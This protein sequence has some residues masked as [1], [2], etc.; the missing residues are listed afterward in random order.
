MK[1]FVGGLAVLFVI[2]LAGVFVFVPRSFRAIPVVYAAVGSPEYFTSTEKFVNTSDTGIYIV[3]DM[4]F[5]NSHDNQ[6]T[7]EYDPD[8]LAVFTGWVSPDTSVIH[9]Q[10][11]R[12]APV[13][14]LNGDWYTSQEW[15][16]DNGELT[17][18]VADWF[19]TDYEHGVTQAMQTCQWE[20]PIISVAGKYGIRARALAEV[21]MGT[22]VEYREIVHPKGGYYDYF[23]TIL[24]AEDLTSVRLF[25]KFGR[26]VVKPDPRGETVI[27]IIVQ[28]NEGAIKM[29]MKRNTSDLGLTYEFGIIEDRLDFDWSNPNEVK[30]SITKN[31]EAFNKIG[32]VL[33]NDILSL[34]VPAKLDAGKYLIMVE[35]TYNGVVGTFIID[36]GDPRMTIFDKMNMRVIM[37]LF[38]WTGLIALFG[39]LFIMYGSKVAYSMNKTK[40]KKIDDKI[41]EMD[42]ASIRKREKAEKKKQEAIKKGEIKAERAAERSFSRKMEEVQA[43]REAARAQGMTMEE[44]KKVAAQNA[45]VGADGKKVNTLRGV[46]AMIAEE[47]QITEDK[48]EPPSEHLVKETGKGKGLLGKIETALDDELNGGQE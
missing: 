22:S 7:E 35:H 18:N 27:D 4:T 43:M 23:F 3:R 19:Y 46:R 26:N 1:K 33:E 2:V 10:F 42:A 36:N 32:W 38:V 8:P 14:Y 9:E 5:I 15:A 45:S 17:D 16:I 34:T 11:F 12:F 47:A 41:Y 29:N 31:G 28:G 25:D 6:L 48:I 13:K 39:A 20:L 37:H 21:R 40:Y 24:Y 44:Y 30:V